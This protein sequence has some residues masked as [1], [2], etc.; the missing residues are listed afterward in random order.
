MMERPMWKVGIFMIFTFGL[1]QF[2]WLGLTWSEMKK[3]IKDDSMCPVWHA[4]AML[5]PIYSFFRLYNHYKTINS[6]LGKVGHPYK[7]YPGWVILGTIVS[8]FL[9]RIPG[10]DPVFV[11]ILIIAFLGIQVRIITHGQKG[12]NR[13]FTV[14]REK[15]LVVL[16]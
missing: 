3:E 4:L 9:S 14:S 6:L 16:T 2:V 7:V 11:F 5:V 12:L 8:I 13:Y 15:S 10:E 1:Y